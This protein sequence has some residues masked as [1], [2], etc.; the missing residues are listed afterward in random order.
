MHREATIAS[1]PALKRFKVAAPSRVRPPGST[2]ATVR[3]SPEVYAHAFFA[4]LLLTIACLLTFA[5]QSRAQ[6]LAASIPENAH[7]KSYG[8]GWECDPSF[9][10]AAGECVAIVL[11][12]NAYLTNRAYRKGWE[13]LHG[14]VE[15]DGTSCVEF[16]VPAGGYLD[17]TGGKWRCLRGYRETG[18]ACEQIVLPDHAY[19]T[20]DTFGSDWA[21]DRGY[22][23]TSDD[24][25]AIVVP[26]NAFLNSATHGRPWLC[27]RGFFEKNGACEAVFVPANAYFHDASYGRKWKCNRGY[28]ANDE[29]CTAI[30][31]PPN[32]HLDRSG[33]GWECHRNFQL[34]R[35]KCVFEN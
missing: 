19:L 13:C 35:G 9:K 2:S 22:R 31:M 18:G 6:S 21:C 15:V 10:I 14:F 23:K 30:V 27:E 4:L 26:E 17:P 16:V 24:C 3:A 28:A 12:A 25:V 11:P 7:A 32:A 34:S 33:N 20:E 8:A 5:G 1:T 29:S